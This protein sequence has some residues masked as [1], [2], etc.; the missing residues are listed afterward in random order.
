MFPC[1]HKVSKRNIYVQYLQKQYAKS[2]L[3]QLIIKKIVLLYVNV[4]SQQIININTKIYT[5][6]VFWKFS[7]TSIR[8]GA[9]PWS[10]SN[11]T[12]LQYTI[13]LHSVCTVHCPKTAACTFGSS[14][15]TWKYTVCD[16]H[17]KY[18]DCF[19]FVGFLRLI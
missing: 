18:E 6:R 5:V 3:Y 1:K 4:N 17:Y 10:N 9:A 11:F 12:N 8:V 14:H 16:G 13:T 19:I 7:V 2:I 15:A